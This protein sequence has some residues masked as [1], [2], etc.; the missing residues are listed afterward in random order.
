MMKEDPR[1]VPDVPGT[2]RERLLRKLV[3]VEMDSSATTRQAEGLRDS[4][5]KLQK[6]KSTFSDERGSSGRS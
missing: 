3:E 2:Q 1:S 6:V 4:L 5:K